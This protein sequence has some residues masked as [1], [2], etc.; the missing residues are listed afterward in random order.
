[1]NDNKHKYIEFCKEQALPLHMQP[2]W[3]DAVCVEGH[4]G[5]AL[6]FDGLG[7]I[8]GVLP[9]YMPDSFWLRTIRMPPFSDYAGIWLRISDTPGMKPE[10]CYDIEMRIISALCDQ[11]PRVAFYDQSL[12]PD[13]DNWLPFYWQGYRQTTRYTYVLPPGAGKEVLYGSFRS[14]L[15]KDLRKA[16]SRVVITQSDSPEDF[17]RV[18]E[19]SFAKQ[20]M[21]PAQSL[22]NL[23]RMDAAAAAHHCRRIYLARDGENGALHAGLYVVW[24]DHQAYLLLSGADPALRASGALF[25]LQWQAIQDFTTK[26]LQVDFCGS[27]LPKVEN[28]LRAFGA[29]RKEYYRIYKAGNRFWRLLALLLNKDY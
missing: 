13:F 5:V 16:E 25:L 27:V 9:Y 19:R 29:E 17:Y 28:A 22:Q 18:Y 3:L 23:L 8:N 26:G 10:R 2:W 20:N 11:L 15:K 6:S 21:A 12:F 14:S 24:D 1:M 7:H 4:W